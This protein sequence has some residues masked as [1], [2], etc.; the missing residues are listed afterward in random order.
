MAHWAKRTAAVWLLRTGIEG[1]GALRT[2]GGGIVAANVGVS[3]GD[4]AESLRTAGSLGKIADHYLSTSNHFRRVA[5]TGA[6][7]GG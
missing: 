2:R 6:A 7:D 3:A 1:R 5:A 4:A